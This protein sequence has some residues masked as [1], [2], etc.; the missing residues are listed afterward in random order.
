MK[1]NRLLA[2][3]GV[4]KKLSLREKLS[5]D[6][7][8]HYDAIVK[9]LKEN[10]NVSQNQT[11]PSK[12]ENCRGRWL[13][14]LDEIDSFLIS[15]FVLP[16]LTRKF[17]QSFKTEIEYSSVFLSFYDVVE[18]STLIKLARLMSKESIDLDVKFM[19]STGSIMELW[20]LK[21]R[22]VRICPLTSLSQSQTSNTKPIIWQL[23]CECLSWEVQTI[24]Q[25]EN[26]GTMN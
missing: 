7:K 15:D 23:E 13:V 20:K 3:L 25:N 19:N 1:W 16:S 8:V 14:E 4:R 21:V 17:T 9:L 10:P 18:S 2:F 11:L 22:P 24:D 5:L 26:A 6:G 12:F